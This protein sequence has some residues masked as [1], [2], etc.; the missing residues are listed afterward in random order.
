[1][2]LGLD[3]DTMDAHSDRKHLADAVNRYLEQ[4]E[5]V[6]LDVGN[7]VGRPSLDGIKEEGYICV[8]PGN[9]D[10]EQDVYSFRTGDGLNPNHINTILEQDGAEEAAYMVVHGVSQVF[11][12]YVSEFGHVEHSP[13]RDERRR[14]VATV[15]A[16]N[17]ADMD[18]DSIVMVEQTVDPDHEN[19]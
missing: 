18:I 9:N 3:P 16:E 10:R 7:P 6:V 1:M 2:A 11:D 5:G 8:N 13:D 4:G 14:D 17:L 19:G 15:Y 12:Y